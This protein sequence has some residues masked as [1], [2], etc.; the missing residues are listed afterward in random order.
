MAQNVI[1][2]NDYYYVTPYGTVTVV[3]MIEI[4]YRYRYRYTS[5]WAA[6]WLLSTI[7]KWLFSRTKMNSQI[8]LTLLAPLPAPTYNNVR[9]VDTN[10]TPSSSLPWSSRLAP[11]SERISTSDDTCDAWQSTQ[12]A[13]KRMAFN[14]SSK[15]DSRSGCSISSDAIVT[16]DTII[17][18]H[19][20]DKFACTLSLLTW[21]KLVS[22][23]DE[24]L[25]EDARQGKHDRHCMGHW[26]RGCQPDLI[27]LFR[28]ETAR[29]SGRRG[30][31]V[32]G[33]AG[34]SR[35]QSVIVEVGWREKSG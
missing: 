35:W 18:V 7:A 29:H 15:S 28:K 30:V 27:I 5:C 6:F 17:I 34:R 3:Q 13:K 4:Y 31:G 26:I 10:L 33:L 1:L 14:S 2:N 32:W 8:A 12:V 21:P 9:R 23:A 25:H 24:E 16:A 20:H 11:M 22:V 19:V